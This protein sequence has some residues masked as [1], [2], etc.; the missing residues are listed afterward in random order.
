MFKRDHGEKEKMV[1]GDE[2]ARIGG[3]SSHRMTMR[4]F[5]ITCYTTLIVL[6]SGTDNCPSTAT[7]EKGYLRRNWFIWFSSH[8]WL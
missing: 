1:G 8:M 4:N 6:F 7:L 5:H 3:S 2:A